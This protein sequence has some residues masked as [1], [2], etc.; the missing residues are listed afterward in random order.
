MII[1]PRPME[2]IEWTDRMALLVDKFG[3]TMKLND[4]EDWR[5]W[6]QNVIE[7][8]GLSSASVNPYSYDDWKPWAIRFS[9]EAEGLL[10]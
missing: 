3:L 10:Q 6:A 7:L 8:I 9:Q 2:V 5:R 1:D 4:P